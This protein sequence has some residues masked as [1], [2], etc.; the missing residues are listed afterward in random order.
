L[1]GFDVFHRVLPALRLVARTLHFAR[2]ATPQSGTL[3][4]GTRAR[5]AALHATGRFLR[6][7][8]IVSP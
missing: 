1:K 4:N 7:V 3:L 2:L 5:E 8:R 6:F